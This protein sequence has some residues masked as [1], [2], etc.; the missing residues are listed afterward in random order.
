MKISEIIDNLKTVDIPTVLNSISTGRADFCCESMDPGGAQMLVDM[1]EMTLF[2][3]ALHIAELKNITIPKFKAEA[4][5]DDCIGLNT[6]NVDIMSPVNQDFAKILHDIQYGKYEDLST[7]TTVNNSIHVNY[8][9]NMRKYIF[10]LEDNVRIINTT[11]L[12]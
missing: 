11:C 1:T 10:S 9:D 8:T 12:S 5:A 2:I 7:R 3:A 6:I 4:C